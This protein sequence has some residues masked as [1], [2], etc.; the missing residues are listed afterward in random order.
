MGRKGIGVVAW[1]AE[2]H[3][4][5]ADKAADPLHGPRRNLSL[6]HIVQQPCW[7]D[8]AEGPS[9]VKQ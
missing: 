9:L 5:V 3:G 1:K 4:Y 7:Y 8:S 6:P 2:G